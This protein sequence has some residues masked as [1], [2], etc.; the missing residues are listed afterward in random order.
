METIL[1]YAHNILLFWEV[2]KQELKFA[3]LKLILARIIM[4][5]IRSQL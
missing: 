3:G 2:G 4:V 1:L 5:L